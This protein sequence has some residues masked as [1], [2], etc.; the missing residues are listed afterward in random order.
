MIYTTTRFEAQQTTND[1]LLIGVGTAVH[2]VAVVD[3]TMHLKFAASYTPGE[4]D[5]EISAVLEHPFSTVKIGVADSLYTF[6][7]S[8]V[9][10]EQQQESYLHYLPFDGVGT[11]GTADVAQLKLKMLY[12]CSRLGWEELAARF[13]D[14]VVYPQ[15]RGL[16]NAVALR[17]GH[18]N[19]PLLIVERHASWTSMAV[20]ADGGFLY[21]HDMEIHQE[22]DFTYYIAAVLEELGLTGREITIQLAGD[23]ETGDGYYARAAAFGG[24]VEL[25]DT[26]ILTGIRVPEAVTPHQHR[27]LSLLGLYACAS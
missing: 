8:E 16:L 24:K 6:I 3:Q 13:P 25:A 2:T 10:D 20:F 19:V 22:D 27:F 5:P 14:A 15:M 4:V 18:V 26:D 1:T 21:A 17:G 12:Q 11:T 7:P 9:Y 23:V